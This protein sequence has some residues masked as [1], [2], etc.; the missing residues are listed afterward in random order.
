MPP[1]TKKRL[2]AE[3]RKAQIVEAALQ[4]FSEKGFSGTRTKEIARLAGISEA[5]VF[6]HFK[7]KEELYNEALRST[8]RGHPIIPD[9]IGKIDRKD[10]F[11]VLFAYADH[12][13][14]HGLKDERMFRL[15]L[16]S[17]LEG[18]R[19]EEHSD[20]PRLGDQENGWEP[21]DEALVRYF[22]ERI[23]D[24]VFKEM[25]PRITVRLFRNSVAMYVADQI[26]KI[27]PDPFPATH[28]EAMAALVG[29]YLNGLK[30]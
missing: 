11:G 15:I 7:S 5:L 6:R 20:R 19:L 25:N 23:G 14:E 27:D 26:L 13:V 12:M 16:Y 30:R 1:E 24:G 9:I 10:D 8:M 3:E 29:I 17:G 22:E 21:A 28:G 4:L 18:V 2:K